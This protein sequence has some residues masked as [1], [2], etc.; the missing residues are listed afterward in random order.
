VHYAI[1]VFI[2]AHFMEFT[3]RVGTKLRLRVRTGPGLGSE[4]R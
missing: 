4:I 2:R 1:P 3:V